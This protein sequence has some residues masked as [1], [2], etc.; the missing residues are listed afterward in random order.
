VARFAYRDDISMPLRLDVD[1]WNS[2]A[3]ADGGER[4]R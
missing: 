3:R 1:A 2:F 4:Y